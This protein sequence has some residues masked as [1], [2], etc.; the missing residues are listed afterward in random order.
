MLEKTKQNLHPN[1][2]LGDSSASIAPASSEG[3][4]SAHNLL[5]K[6]PRAPDLAWNESTAENTDEETQGNQALRVRDQPGHGC[7]NG[8]A[9]QQSNEDEAWTESITKRSCH[10]SD[11]KPALHQLYTFTD[12]KYDI[13]CKQSDDIGV[14]DI[15]LSHVKVTFDGDS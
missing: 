12:C 14:C 2:L 13:R 8:T 9:K 10:K 4:S 3:I 1:N 5:V 7:W 15:F 6:E 11:E